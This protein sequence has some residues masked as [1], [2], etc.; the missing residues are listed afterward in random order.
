[1]FSSRRA[2]VA[3]LLP[4]FA[5]VRA[6]AV[7]RQGGADHL[8]QFAQFGGTTPAC[9]PKIATPPIAADDTYRSGSPLR[10]SFVDARAVG[11][12]LALSG[13]VSGLSCGPI[14]GA[15]VDFWQAD[16]HGMYSSSAGGAFRG[17]QLTD[18]SG[19]F[20]LD[21]I[22]PGAAGHDAP[23]LNVNVRVAGKAD[24]WTRIYFAADPRNGG[25]PGFQSAL[26]METKASDAG[27]TGIF[28][29]VLNL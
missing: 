23:H 24:F 22:V 28:D 12:R 17:H 1:M 4:M 14:A 18:A 11:V 25:D 9:R 16:A 27:K 2:F 20:H 10:T 7:A 21:T 29:L 6:G 5:A 3:G 15:A 19:R 26:A 8:G 13:T